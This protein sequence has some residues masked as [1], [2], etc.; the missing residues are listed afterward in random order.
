MNTNT[1]RLQGA[2]STQLSSRKRLMAA[3]NRSIP[4]LGGRYVCQASYRNNDRGDDVPTARSRT[5]EVVSML[6]NEIAKHA[7]WTFYLFSFIL[8]TVLA[9][10]NLC[11]T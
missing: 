9:L 4:L 1:L 5:V 7:A 11:I 8:Q 6:E 2:K 10:N 3:S